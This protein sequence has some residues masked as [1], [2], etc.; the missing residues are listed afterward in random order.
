MARKRNRKPIDDQSPKPLL[1]G[2]DILYEAK[3]KFPEVRIEK[4]KIIHYIFKRN[5]KTQRHD[6]TM[7]SKYNE[8]EDLI[9]VLNNEPMYTQDRKR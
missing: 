3:Q 2:P 4:G 1:D 5:G 8:K 6:S 7:I 9:T